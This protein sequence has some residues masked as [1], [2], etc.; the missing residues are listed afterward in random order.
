M[1]TDTSAPRSRQPRDQRH[2]ALEL[3]LDRH[4]RA[5]ADGRLAAD[6][7]DVRARLKQRLAVRDLLGQGRMRAAVGEGVRR[8]VDD[9]HQQRTRAQLQHAV[10]QPQDGHYFLIRSLTVRRDTLPT[11]S[12]ALTVSVKRPAR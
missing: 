6:V 9:A 4:G 2:D 10:A 5:A 12:T 7:E 3:L 11:L 1:S 8:R